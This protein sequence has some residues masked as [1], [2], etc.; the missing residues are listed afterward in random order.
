MNRRLL[1]WTILLISTA[2]VLSWIV[3]PV[4]PARPI[5]KSDSLT[6]D[7]YIFEIEKGYVENADSMPRDQVDSVFSEYR[8]SI[9]DAQVSYSADSSFKIFVIELEGCGAYCN[10]QW[11]SWTHFNLK[12]KEVIKKAD[13]LNASN[14][15][16]TIDSIYKLP[17]NKF[18]VVEK[19]W[20]RPASVLTVFCMDTKLIS[21]TT[22]SLIIHPIKYRGADNFAFCQENGVQSDKQPFIKYN[23]DKKLLTYYYGNNYAYSRGVDSDTLRQGQFKYIKGQFILDKETFTVRQDTAAGK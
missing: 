7:K 21:F 12:G 10:P 23:Q 1:T 6:I 14:N 18:L 17:D 4:L 13:F 9:A 8:L 3:A 20:A 5:S 16:T 11:F 19:S 15:F 22:D 2:I